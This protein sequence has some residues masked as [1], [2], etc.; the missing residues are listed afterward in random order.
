M[1]PLRLLMVE[2]SEDDAELILR[3][4]HR[5]GLDVSHRRVETAGAMRDALL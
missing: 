4:L 1:R 2:D 5:G 3:E